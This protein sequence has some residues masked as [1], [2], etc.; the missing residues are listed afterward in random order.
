MSF[1]AGGSHAPLGHEDRGKQATPPFAGGAANP[2]ENHE[3]W[4]L[5]V[6]KCP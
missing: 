1:R 5:S 6:L 4:N 3:T 2:L